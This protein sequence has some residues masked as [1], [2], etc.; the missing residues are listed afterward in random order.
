MASERSRLATVG[1]FCGIAGIAC[2]AIGIIGI[3]IRLFPPMLGFGLFAL[4]TIVGGISA[5]LLGGLALVRK[6]NLTGPD[7]AKRAKT[8]TALGAVLLILLFLSA[9]SGGDAPSINDITTDLSNPPAFASA[10]E[11]PAYQGRDMGYP[12]EFVPIVKQAYPDLAPSLMPMLPDE[13]YQKALATAQTMGLEVVWQSP[14]ERRFDAI[15][16][17]PV[18]RFVDD[19]TVRVQP[20]GSGSVVDIRSKSRDGKGDLGTNAKRIRTFVSQLK[21]S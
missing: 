20:A 13:T 4:A 15:D 16:V 14:E 6:K 18:F 11:V 3:Q 19:I 9:G 8:A 5:T 21:A 1:Y 17:T 10:G 7:D 2:L 12:P